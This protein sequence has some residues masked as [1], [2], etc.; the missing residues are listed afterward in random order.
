MFE[1]QFAVYLGVSHT[2]VIWMT[3]L[4]HHLGLFGLLLL[5]ICIAF[6]NYA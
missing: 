5:W 4:S 2:A 3:N 6:K 1:L